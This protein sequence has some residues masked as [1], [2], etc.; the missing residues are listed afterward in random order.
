M[1][2]C[3]QQHMKGVLPSLVGS[4]QSSTLMQTAIMCTQIYCNYIHYIHILNYKTRAPTSMPGMVGS[5]WDGW[6]CG[7][8]GGTDMLPRWCV[9]TLVCQR[10]GVLVRV[11]GHSCV[12]GK[13]AL[14]RRC[15][16][17]SARWCII[18]VR[19]RIG[20]SARRCIGVSVRGRIGTLVR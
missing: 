12:G 20:T 3:M 18:L 6:A 4:T 17:V 14:A 7:C 5:A 19:G 13:D 11:R 15:V 1:T 2:W 16:G 8:T 9:G 10:V